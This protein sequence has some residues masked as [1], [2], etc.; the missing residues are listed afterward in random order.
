L[1]EICHWCQHHRSETELNYER[2]SSA[3]LWIGEGSARPD[4]ARWVTG[5]NGSRPPISKEE[6]ESVI[7]GTED[8]SVRVLTAHSPERYTWGD[9]PFTL[10]N[11]WIVTVFVDG[12]DF[13]YI[14]RIE[15]PDGR[16]MDYGEIVSMWPS[17]GGYRPGTERSRSVWGLEY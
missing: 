13:D 14:D 3:L 17:L 1:T 7:R 9:E 11:G 10:S 8:G 12:G 5:F 6:I 15:A 4:L 16:Y 2:F